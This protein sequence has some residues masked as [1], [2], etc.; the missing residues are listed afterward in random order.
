[1]ASSPK[2]VAIIGNGSIDDPEVMAPLIQSYDFIIAADGGAN[3]CHAMKITPNLI[4]GD[5]D[6]IHQNVKKSF[7]DVKTLE[8]P[9]D[10]DQ[11]DLELSLDAALTFNPSKITLFAVSGN[12]IDHTLANLYLL[13]RHPFKLFIETETEVLFAISKSTYVDCH[14]NQTLSLLPLGL[15]AKGVSTQGLKW[16]LNNATIDH[17]GLSVSNVALVETV[18]IS[19]EKGNLLCCLNK[20]FQS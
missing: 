5:L 3:H 8:Y 16:E 19:I 17:N 11:T 18:H 13:L 2:T 15:A 4:I 6:S 9:S 20:T 14:V 7:S 1:M 12:R 10:K